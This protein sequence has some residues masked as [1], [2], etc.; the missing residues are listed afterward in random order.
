[1]S[2]ASN[3]TDRRRFQ[4]VLFDS[5]AR[6]SDGDS[7]FITTLMDISLK[8]AFLI[9]PEEWQIANGRPVVLT[10]LLADGSSTIRMEALVAHQQEDSLGLRCER[11]DM[12]SIAHLRRLLELNTEDPELMERELESLGG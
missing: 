10:V 5:P 4:R 3:T 7:E 12:E 9:R 1:M 6:I 11:I 2:T 8:G